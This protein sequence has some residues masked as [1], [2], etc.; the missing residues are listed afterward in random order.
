[1]SDPVSNDLHDAD[2]QNTQGTPGADEE[3]D[4]ASGGAPMR[5][6]SAASTMRPTTIRTG[7]VLPPGVTSTNST[8][9]SQIS[10]ATATGISKR[11][12]L[13]PPSLCSRRLRT[14]R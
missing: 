11:P 3:A 6:I 5:L 14:A 2:H 13:K 10:A 1:M 9:A 12:R 4:T 8:N 7:M